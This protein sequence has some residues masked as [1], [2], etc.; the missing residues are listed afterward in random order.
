MTLVVG[1]EIEVKIEKLVYGGSGLARHQGLVVF[2]DYSS[3]QE[4]CLVKV[5]KIKKNYVEAKKI[6]SIQAGPYQRIAEC[7]AFGR[8]GACHWM[9]TS[10]EE[11]LRQKQKIAEENLKTHYS[12]S[13]EIVA[14]KEFHY[15]NRLQIR[16]QGKKVGY[17]QK[18]SHKIVDAKNC[19][20]AEKD[21]LPIF[22]EV[23]ERNFSR[24]T[25]IE[26]FKNAKGEI[27]QSINKKHG[28]ES[29]FRQIN[30]QINQRLIETVSSWIQIEKCEL[31]YDLYCGQGNFAAALKNQRPELEVHAV[32]IS[33]ANIIK[34]KKLHPS[35][36]FYQQDVELW[37]Q[38]SDLQRGSIVVIDPPREGASKKSL[39]HL[40][41]KEILLLYI[42]CNPTTLRRDLDY[43]KSFQQQWEV[44][45]VKAFDMFPQTYHF[46]LAC[47]LK[48]K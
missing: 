5:I 42:S 13:I 16:A 44:L 29:G 48:C 8:C 27:Q 37:L 11:Q 38:E 4:V 45:Q 17:L 40:A 18:N 20:V 39:E 22:D 31:L 41:K 46:E 19:L 25:K 35:V 6:K 23:R 3:P 30:E 26:L 43:L 12:K 47:L 28:Q 24:P 1:Q 34:A 10:Y 21:F 15:R 14:S 9:N 36:H 33:K 2:V 7:E 32:D